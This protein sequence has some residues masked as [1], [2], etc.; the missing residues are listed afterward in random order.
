M[1][2]RH[3][4][5][6]A[7]AGTRA[8]HCSHPR[9][10]PF[11]CASVPNVRTTRDRLSTSSATVLLSASTSWK[12]CRH[13]HTHAHIGRWRSATV[14]ASSQP[15]SAHTG[16]PGASGK[17][18]ACIRPACLLVAARK[19]PVDERDCPQHRA[20]GQRHAAHGGRQQIQVHHAACRG[21]RV[22]GR[23]GAAAAGSVDG[24]VAA[25]ALPDGAGTAAGRRL[26]GSRPGAPA[27]ALP[28]A[29]RHGAPR[30]T[31]GGHAAPRARLT[32]CRASHGRG[33]HVPVSQHGA[34]HVRTHPA[35]SHV[36]KPPSPALPC[37]GAP[38]SWQAGRPLAC[39]Y[40]DRPPPPLST[41]TYMHTGWRAHLLPA[42]GCAAQC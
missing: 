17:H 27:H 20:D 14:P 9:Y 26:A 21:S 28:P 12:I 13:T 24:S 15:G 42:V 33:A 32:P 18:K 16:Q 39:R 23:A 25:S 2:R 29:A 34:D 10:R 37:P 19:V 36:R 41:H 35:H 3:A 5:R 4:R 22:G 6:A 38:L 8:T 40:G 30:R 31:A 1:H 7:C 11:S